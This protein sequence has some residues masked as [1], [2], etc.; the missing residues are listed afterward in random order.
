MPFIDLSDP[1]EM[2]SLLLDYVED[3]LSESPKDARRGQFLSRLIEELSDL[4]ERFSALSDK[5]RARA[6][7]EMIASIDP[8]F[9]SDPVAEHLAACAEEIDRIN[10]QDAAQ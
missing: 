6:L 1:E 2:L 4:E 10:S 9:K 3:E 8:E 7:R 5:E